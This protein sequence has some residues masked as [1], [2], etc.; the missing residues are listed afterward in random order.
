VPHDRWGE[1][2]KALVV[3][4]ADVE[5]TE[6]EIIAWCKERL[7]RYKAPTSVD[8]VESIPR[9]ATGKVQKFRIRESYWAGR[10]RTVN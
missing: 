10:E 6:D 1:T 4:V 7:A 9:T 2:I 8:F 3:A 5:V